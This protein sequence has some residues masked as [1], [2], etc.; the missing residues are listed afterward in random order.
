MFF[1]FVQILEISKMSVFIKTRD[2][3][4]VISFKP[5]YTFYYEVE[6][7]EVNDDQVVLFILCFIRRL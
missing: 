5:Y 7:K 3:F 2:I 4:A 6:P 1:S